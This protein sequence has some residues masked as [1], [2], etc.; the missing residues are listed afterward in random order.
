MARFSDGYDERRE[1][2]RHREFWASEVKG[3]YLSV[4]VSE[5]CC[6]ICGFGLVSRGVLSGAMG[7]KQWLLCWISYLSS[8]MTCCSGVLDSVT[9][10]SHAIAK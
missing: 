7:V 5:I 1:G 3:G 6:S 10:V 8:Q 2:G 4:S 9:L